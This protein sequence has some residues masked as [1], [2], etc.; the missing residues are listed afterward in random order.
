VVVQLADSDVNLAGWALLLSVR[1]V[2]AL[3]L[4]ECGQRKNLN[5]TGAF[6]QLL[7]GLAVELAMFHRVF[8]FKDVY[9]ACFSTAE[10][11]VVDG[12]FD[13]LVDAAL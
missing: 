8:V 4:E 6:L 10:L 12:P 5:T 3:V 7:D 2:V 11:H 13:D 1:A 9:A